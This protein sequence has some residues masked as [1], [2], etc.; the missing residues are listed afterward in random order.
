MRG[1][2]GSDAR[3][4]KDAETRLQQIMTKGN[5]THDQAVQAAEQSGQNY[6]ELAYR[7][8]L[9]I[10]R[11]DVQERYKAKEGFW[12][13]FFSGN[14]VEQVMNDVLAADSHFSG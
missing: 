2:P 13:T 3:G 1:Q 8:L 11:D 10:M 7:A 4:N 6:E 14:V 9:P 12:G 5:M